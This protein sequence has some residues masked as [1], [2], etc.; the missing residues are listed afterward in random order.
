[1][2]WTFGIPLAPHGDGRAKSAVIA[3]HVHLYRDEKDIRWQDIIAF[4]ADRVIPREVIEGA[5][6]VDVL[7]LL[8]RPKRL[9]KRSKRTGELLGGAEE[10]LMWAPVMPDR[11]NIDKAIL[12]GLKAIWRDDQQVCFGWI[13]K[14]YAEANGRPRL[15]VTVWTDLGPVPESLQRFAA[16]TAIMDF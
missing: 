6:R 7:A 8:P 12:D 15:I 10:G 3:G 16:E 13:A 5:M 2:K 11:D 1:M 14:C 4:A 9:L